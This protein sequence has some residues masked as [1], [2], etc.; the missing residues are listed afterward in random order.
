MKSQRQIVIVEDNPADVFLF[1]EALRDR[2][3]RA[4]VDRYADGPDALRGLGAAAAAPDLIVLDL[5]LPSCSGLDIL[6]WIRRT[7]LLNKVPVA[8]LTSS[9]SPRDRDSCLDRG[10]TRYVVKPMELQPF[11]ADVGGAVF[12]LLNT[13]APEGPDCASTAG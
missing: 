13:R 2:G 5:N 6:E 4:A 7:P 10:A 8:V 3:V 11:L 9:A 1:C 12:E